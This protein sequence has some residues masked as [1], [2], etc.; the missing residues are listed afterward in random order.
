MTMLKL[1][2]LFIKILQVLQTNGRIS[3]LDLSEEVNLSPSPCLERVRK[4]EE[5]GLI[6]QYLAEIDLDKIGANLHIMA[7][8]TLGNHL[9]DDF[10][11]FEAAITD[12]P[13]VI[14]CYKIAGPFDYTMDMICRD[15]AHFN[16]LKEKLLAAK[17]GIEHFR[18]HVVMERTKTFSGYPLES[19]TAP[20]P[21]DGVLKG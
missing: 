8:I 3:N 12:V 16:Q 4:L 2:R 5:A 14:S 6:T 13:E 11:R 19:L 20:S 18:G 7:E 10:K 9:V 15:I 21:L 17:I 1:D